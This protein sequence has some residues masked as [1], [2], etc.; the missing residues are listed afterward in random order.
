MVYRQITIP[1]DNDDA[2]SIVALSTVELLRA[3]LLEITTQNNIQQEVEPGPQVTRIVTDSYK[4]PPK[5]IWWAVW[6]NAAVFAAN[7]K[8][9]PCLNLETGVTLGFK[10]SMYLSIFGQIPLSHISIGSNDGHAS[11]RTSMVASQ[12][13]YMFDKGKNS[14]IA[15]G[16]GGGFAAVMYRVNG[17]PDVGNVGH[18]TLLATGMPFIKSSFLLKITPSVAI[19]MDLMLGATLSQI[20]VDVM[21]SH[22]TSFGYFVISGAL[23]LYIKF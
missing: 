12:L 3:S 2:D 1:A 20:Q 19:V 14:R 16:T 9:L 23:G 21:A 13:G 15:F 4:P 17:D 11:I 22:N 5:K 7:M 18:E 6:I 8:E 10:N